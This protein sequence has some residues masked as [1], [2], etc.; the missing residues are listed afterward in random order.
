[1]NGNAIFHYILSILEG[2]L[3][4][5]FFYR[6][7]QTENKKRRILLYGISALWFASSALDALIGGDELR[8]ARA[9]ETN[10]GGNENE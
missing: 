3:S 5:A 7:G 6:A 8:D 9:L 2:F 10:D 4:G 1:M